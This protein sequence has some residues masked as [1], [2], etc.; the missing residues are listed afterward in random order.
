MWKKFPIFLMCIAFA[1]FLY[2]QTHKLLTVYGTSM[3]PT[4]KERDVCLIDDVVTPVRGS[5]Y[6]VIEPETNRWAIKRLIGLPGDTVELVDGNTVVNGE[7][8][9]LPADGTWEN[10]KFTLGADEYLFLG[11]NREDSYDGRHWDRPIY[12]SEI[13]YE[14]VFRIYPMSKMGS[15]N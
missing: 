6:V 11:D 1:F 15:L 2:M 12:R 7:K 14:A 13:L 9:E 5:I 8:L 4:L 10:M 3:E